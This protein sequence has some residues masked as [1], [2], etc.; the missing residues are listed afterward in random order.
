MYF[1]RSLY[2]FDFSLWYYCINLW[3][4]DFL[5][6]I[7]IFFSYLFHFQVSLKCFVVIFF[8]AFVILMVTLWQIRSLVDSAV[9]LIALF[10]TILIESLTNCLAWS[11][12]FQLFFS[13]KFL[14][15]FLPIY[16][17]KFL[18]KMQLLQFYKL[19]QIFGLLLELNSESF[20]IFWT[21]INN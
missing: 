10:E 2:F 20:F 19:L 4:A 8:E 14:V 12:S 16:L 9:F 6:E 11:G 18:A 1:L 3:S 21:W 7:Y 17:P 15:I 13:L 5:L